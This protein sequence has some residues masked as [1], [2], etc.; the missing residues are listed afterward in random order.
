MASSRSSAP[1]SWSWPSTAM[2]TRPPSRS[3]WAT[4]AG[5][6][7]ATA[8]GARGVCLPKRGAR[9]REGCLSAERAVVRLDLV[10]AELVGLRHVAQRLDVELL[11]HDGLQALDRRPLAPGGHDDRRAQRLAGLPPGLPPWGGAPP[12]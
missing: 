8:A 1:S 2:P 12:A 5:S 6:S 4:C 3:A 10:G 7:A 9:G 11:E